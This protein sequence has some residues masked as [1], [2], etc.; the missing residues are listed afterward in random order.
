MDRKKGIPDF[1]AT[2]SE[3]SLLKLREKQNDGDREQHSLTDWEDDFWTER[4]T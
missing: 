4:S 1:L 2:A 3:N